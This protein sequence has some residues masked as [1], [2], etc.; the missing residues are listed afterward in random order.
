MVQPN[1]QEALVKPS[2]KKR[3]ANKQNTVSKQKERAKAKHVCKVFGWPRDGTK[4]VIL[5]QTS[6]L[7]PFMMATFQG[8]P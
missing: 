4:P 6:P 1:M 3:K 8:F 5:P 2:T 7:P